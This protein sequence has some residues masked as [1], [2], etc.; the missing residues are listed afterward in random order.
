MFYTLASKGEFIKVQT[1]HL[2]VSKSLHFFIP[3]FSIPAILNPCNFISVHTNNPRSF[4]VL[5]GFFPLQ[6]LEKTG[7]KHRDAVIKN[8]GLK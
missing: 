8:Q 2:Y 5:T 6:R 4:L 7:Y 3:A 1:F